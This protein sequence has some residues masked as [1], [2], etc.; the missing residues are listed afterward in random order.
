[1]RS[2]PLLRGVLGADV[3]LGLAG[4]LMVL[5][6]LLRAGTAPQVLPE[7]RPEVLWIASAEGLWLPAGGLVPLA[8][9]TTAP[10]AWPGAALHLIVEPSGIEAA[11][12]TEARLAATPRN[13]G[14]A[15]RLTLKRLA[16]PCPRPADHEGPLCA[17]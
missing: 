1:M 15:A 17:R 8:E 12:L 10:L 13:D 9:L 11:F 2:D 14:G 4:I 16:D 5:M 6:S 7:D 3:M